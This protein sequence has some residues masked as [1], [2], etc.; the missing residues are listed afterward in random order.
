MRGVDVPSASLVGQRD[1]GGEVHAGE[2]QLQSMQQQLRDA[3]VQLRTNGRKLSSMTR[4]LAAVG[5]GLKQLGQTCGSGVLTD[6]GINTPVVNLED[7]DEASLLSMVERRISFVLDALQS[8]G[9]V[10]EGS[11]LEVRVLQ[12]GQAGDKS[13]RTA[14]GQS[15]EK[16][17]RQN[18]TT[19]WEPG[20]DPNV[21]VPS[22]AMRE[23][24]VA[25][26]SI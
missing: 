21:R 18:Q 14:R 17:S 20:L 6:L 12:L 15:K 10:P 11:Q 9:L 1:V 7:D 16:V 26:G 3:D 24:H 5:P 25:A 8:A 4:L 2:Q 13:P 19:N 22:R 23:Q